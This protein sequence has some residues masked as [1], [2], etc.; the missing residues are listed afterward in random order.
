[1]VSDGPEELKKKYLNLIG[2]LTD[3]LEISNGTDLLKG[4]IDKSANFS[5]RN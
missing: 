4:L 3:D 2:L 1:M 5:K